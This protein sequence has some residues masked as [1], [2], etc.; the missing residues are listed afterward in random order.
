MKRFDISNPAFMQAACAKGQ[1]SEVDYMWLQTLEDGCEVGFYVNPDAEVQPTIYYSID[2]HTWQELTNEGEIERVELAKNA[3]MYFKGEN[4]DGLN[5][6]D[7]E[8]V[9]HFSCVGKFDTGGNIM[10]LI[11][12]DN[13]G[14]TTRGAFSL[15]YNLESDGVDI[16]NAYELKL[17]ATELSSQCYIYMFAGC[18]SLITAPE[19]PATTLADQC[20]VGM[21]T[22]C[23]SLQTAPD[24]PATTLTNDCYAEMF[25]GSALRN[26]PELPATTLEVGSY[27]AMFTGCTLLNYVKCLATDISA[28]NCTK[29][30]LDDVAES[31]TF[32]K[33]AGMTD[34]TTGV[35]GIPTGWTV[36]EA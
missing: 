23:T 35:N 4:E 28:Y 11:D 29:G 16:V 20:Y 3:K 30:W 33:A 25:A 32:V 36:E 2:K 7:S 24:L 6:I 13:P 1:S 22:L 26:A 14:L 18:T 5:E 21:F 15:F 8:Y 34:W 9:N 10:T 17:P 19:L 27:Y 31:G 12:G